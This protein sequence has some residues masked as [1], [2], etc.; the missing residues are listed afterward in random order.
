MSRL[1]SNILFISIHSPHARGDGVVAA[2]MGDGSLISIHSPHARGDVPEDESVDVIDISI[3]SP[4]ARGDRR[5]GKAKRRESDF[6]PLPSCEGRPDVQ[7]ET[8]P[9]LGISIHSPHARGDGLFQR[10]IR[11]R[12]ISIH[13]PHARGDRRQVAISDF[14]RFQSTPLMRGETSAFVQC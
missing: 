6:N 2:E 1:L 4:H 10:R 12:S 9:N 7:R 5:L 3:H 8:A 14:C 11:K 13:S